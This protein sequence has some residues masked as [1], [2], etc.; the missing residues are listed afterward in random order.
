MLLDLQEKMSGE[1][2][3]FDVVLSNYSLADGVYVIVKKHSTIEITNV[4]KGEQQIPELSW[5]KMADYFSYLLEINKAVDDKKQIH[6]CN[7]YSVFVKLDKL[8]G[9]EGAKNLVSLSQLKQFIKY[10]FSIFEKEPKE[11]YKDEEMEALQAAG[12]PEFDTGIALKNKAWTEEHIEEILD[13]IKGAKTA[14]NAYLK[15]FFYEDIDEYKREWLRYLIPKIFNKS[16]FNIGIDGKIYG[17][18]NFNM[19]MNSKKPYLKLMSTNFEVPYRISFE[20]SLQ[21]KYIFDWMENYKTSDGRL[22]NSLYIPPK[23]DFHFHDDMDKFASGQYIRFER[24]TSTEI[25]DYDYIPQECNPKE[26]FRVRNVTDLESWDVKENPDR[27]ELEAILSQIFFN[28]YLAKHY[29]TDPSDMKDKYAEG[30]YSRK[31]QSLL[32]IYRKALF[33]FFRKND[34]TS[35]IKCFDRL[36]ME[37][38]Q[39]YIKISKNTFSYKA[40]KAFNLRISLLEHFKLGRDENM[41]DMIASYY[42]KVRGKMLEKDQVVGCEDDQEFF[43]T[44]GQVTSYLLSQSEAKDLKHSASDVV[45]NTKNARLLKDKLAGLFFIYNHAL[46]KNN[47]RFN[48]LYSMVMGYKSEASTKEYMDCFLAGMLCRNMLYEKKEEK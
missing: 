31:L 14:K 30:E 28:W 11:R 29:Y 13:R 9:I 21:L 20:E 26:R 35:F 16:D 41:P 27:K 33:D 42:E 34:D 19:G 3:L 4:L 45:I 44:A 23:K 17:L 8:P 36:S 6:S 15:I 25:T 43:F 46:S 47:Y 1:G 40:S 37:V 39:E 48:N 5:L 18:S 32:V 12:L 7:P 22:V 2:E 10:Y 38:V 24:G